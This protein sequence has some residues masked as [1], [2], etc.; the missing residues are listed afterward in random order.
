MNISD[1][2]E[3][4]KAGWTKEE[5]IALAKVNDA[6][7]IEHPEPNEEPKPEP[8][9]KKEE[10]KPESKEEK[11]EQKPEPNETE[12]LLKALGIKLEAMTSAFQNSNVA[13]MEQEKANVLT[14]DDVVAQMINPHYK[15]E[16]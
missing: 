8:K 6:E 12:K 13:N 5:I 2:L 4:T 14:A 1:I 16:G 10:P 9:E 7:K 3:L 11:E 15:E